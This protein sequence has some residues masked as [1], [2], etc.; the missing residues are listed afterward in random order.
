[1][2]SLTRISS[3]D[4]TRRRWELLALTSVGAFMAPFDGTVVSVA[5]S[6][7][8][9]AL[10]L[11]FT[12]ALWVQAAYLL[13]VAVLLIPLGRLADQHG[14]VHFYLL[15]T[16]IFAVGSLLAGL[17]VSDLMLIGSRVIQGAGAALLTATSAAI[18]TSVFPPRERGRA[19]GI[20][21]TAV[22]VGLCLGAP[23]GGFLVDALGWRSVFYV[24]LP[25]AAAVLAW[26]WLLLP[27]SEKASEARGT[28]FAGA[29]LLGAFLICLLVPLTFAPQWGWASA[30]TIAL[31][32]LAAVSLAGFVVVEHRG[33][34]PVLDLDLL[35]HNRLF[36]TANLA[37]LLNYMAMY[38]V[39]VL[40][41]IFL[42]LVQGRSASATGLI[43]LSQPLLMAVLSPV[44]GH[45]SDRIG[46]RVLSS[47]GMALVA[48]GMGLL[49]TLPED[50]S[51][52]RVTVSLVVVGLGM[53]A[54]SAPNT[55]AIM[56]SVRRD[57]L[58]VASAFL[59]TMRST[60]MALSV[61]LLGGIA[62]SSLGAV[63]GRLLFTHGNGAGAVASAAVRGYAHGY[64][65]AMLAGAGLA[66]V[67]ALVS[68]TRGGVVEQAAEGPPSI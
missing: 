55:S 40:T 64:Q 4:L 46:S 12:A 20:N 54:F 60:G 43:I 19:L 56:G 10:H 25:I 31:L 27:R 8:M 1:M 18:V 37:A 51:T 50:A 67:G 59:G 65:L 33:S 44:S 39:T 2:P 17:S 24:N 26:G 41:A 42:T 13:T 22:Y 9:P 53:A 15:G 16:V 32:V 58:S 11:S 62:A 48:V 61:A 21:V 34:S 45:F 29:A 28:D 3:A 57:Q 63:G 38:A 68:L 35:V 30:H 36:A 5:L 23:V 6:K 14:R 49:G 7:M 47:G 52:M 66:L